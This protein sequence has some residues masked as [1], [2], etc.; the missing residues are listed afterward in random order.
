MNRGNIPL[1]AIKEELGGDYYF[2]CPWKDC[3]K[4]IKSEWNWCPYCGA[5]IIYNKDSYQEDEEEIW[6]TNTR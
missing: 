6:L 5:K 2:R 4:V 3:N 1:E